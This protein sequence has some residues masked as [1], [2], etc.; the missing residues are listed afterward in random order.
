MSGI[1]IWNLLKNNFFRVLKHCDKIYL[2]LFFGGSRK[3]TN[4]ITFF[5]L[6]LIHYISLVNTQERMLLIINTHPVENRAS[7]IH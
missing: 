7:A 2:N 6:S 3:N 4:M 5:S 1:K